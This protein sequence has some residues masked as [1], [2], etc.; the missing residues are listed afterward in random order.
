M[1]VWGEAQKK[2]FQEVKEA[3]ST[4][5]LLA[6]FDPVQETIVSADASSFG[7]G[8]VLLQKQLKGKLCPI[9]YVSRAMTPTEKRYAQIE[10]EALALTWA[11]ERFSDYLIGLQFHLQTDH[12][13][14]DQ[15]ERGG[16]V[17]EEEETADE[18][19]KRRV[20]DERDVAE[21]EKQ[22]DTD[23]SNREPQDE[24]EKDEGEKHADTEILNREPQ[25]EKGKGNLEDPETRDAKD[26]RM[27]AS[28]KDGTHVIRTRSGRIS[29][30]PDY[31]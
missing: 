1:W 6:F 26:P 29:R 17:S 18:Q 14:L 27:E 3:L 16:K 2:A 31:Y 15:D 21:E 5:H 8:A 4:R 12:K 7:L 20:E 10:K 9:A 23:I 24:E 22:V 11:C 28:T 19:G 13:P 30:R 25:D